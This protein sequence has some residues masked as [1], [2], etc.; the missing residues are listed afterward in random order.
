[1]SRA[2]RAGA[3]IAVVLCLFACG[4]I[5]QAQTLERLHGGQGEPTQ[6]RGWHIPVRVTEWIPEPVMSFFALV[7]DRWGAEAVLQPFQ[8]ALA[9]LLAFSVS[10]LPWTWRVARQAATIVHEMGHVIAAFL[11]GRRVRGIKLHTDTSGVMISSGKPRGLGILVTM[12]AGYPAPSLFAVALAVLAGTGHSGAALTLYQLV[13]LCCAFLA[14]NLFGLFSALVS[15]GVTGVIWWYGEP[16]L[17]AFT[18]VALAVFYAVAGLRCTFD[19]IAAHRNAAPGQVLTTDAAQ[20]ARATI[21]PVPA[22]FWLF[23]FILL[24]AISL[25]V[26]MGLLF[27]TMM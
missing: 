12:L 25:I 19:V 15:V 20:A 14:I 27:A 16:D 17:I 5:D 9:A 4:N 8:M 18:V 23:F 22:A 26:V 1:M 7:A 6:P 13:V 2:L 21:V 10:L 11:V 3:L 24:G